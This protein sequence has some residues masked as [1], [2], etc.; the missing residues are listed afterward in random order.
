MSGHWKH[1]FLCICICQVIFLGMHQK[2][3]TERTL[4]VCVFSI[5]W[6]HRGSLQIFD[7][8]KWTHVTLMKNKPLWKSILFRV[9]RNSNWAKGR[10]LQWHEGATFHFIL[11]SILILGPNSEMFCG[12]HLGS[13]WWGTTSTF[14]TP[15]LLLTLTFSL[16]FHPFG[17]LGHVWHSPEDYVTG[18]K[19][20]NEKLLD[21]WEP[22]M[23]GYNLKLMRVI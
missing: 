5:Q 16:L 17:S 3:R 14:I 1:F 23:R 13:K 12:A 4:V 22:T 11:S 7:V 19:K 8:Q 2:T 10:L 9:K 20:C 21:E 15:H 18:I 6:P